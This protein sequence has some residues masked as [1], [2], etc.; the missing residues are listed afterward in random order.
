VS[1]VTKPNI[2]QTSRIDTGRSIERSKSK[3]KEAATKR[4]KGSVAD[5]WHSLEYENGMYEG[6]VKNNKRT[7]K[8][9]YTWQDG[10]WYEGDWVD[11]QKEGMGKF[12]WTTGDIYEGEYKG[13]KRHG[14]GVKT[15]SNGDKYEVRRVYSRENGR[16]EINMEEVL[17]L[18]QTAMSTTASSRITRKKVSASRSGHPDRT[19]RAPG[20]TTRCTERALS[21]GTRETSTRDPI[22]MACEKA[23][24]LRSGSRAPS[25]R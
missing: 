14:V 3:P 17:T 12:S 16:T 5:G 2:S 21:S 20:R 6:Y 18:P 23:K 9:K 10:N 13:D 25:T 8:G 1:N 19:T 24:A 4:L 7:G 11:D 22:S 15:Y